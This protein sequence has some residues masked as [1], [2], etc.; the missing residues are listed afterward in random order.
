MRLDRIPSA[1]EAPRDAVPSTVR[2]A[3]AREPARRR[4][5]VKGMIVALAGAA[6]VPFDWALSRRAAH[7]GPS[8]EWT[9]AN[10]SDGYPGGYGEGANNWWAGG[11]AVCFGGWRMGGFPCDGAKFHFEGWRGYG[12]E[13]Y[14]SNRVTTCAGRNAWRWTAGGGTYRCSDATTTTVWNSGESYTALTIA[15]CLL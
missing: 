6:L 11:P 15:A 1:Q 13:G 8:T 10:C 4:T 5:V 7:A 9:A 2:A 12:D 3:I 14:T